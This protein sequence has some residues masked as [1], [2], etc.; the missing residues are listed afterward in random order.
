MNVLVQGT[1]I[2]QT[3]CL[4]T[5]TTEFTSFI[6]QHLK[7]PGQWVTLLEEIKNGFTVF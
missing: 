1:C 5:T 6:A 7:A 4:E 3:P 2:R